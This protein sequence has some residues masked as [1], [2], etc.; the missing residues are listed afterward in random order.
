MLLATRPQDSLLSANLRAGVSIRVQLL[1]HEL[2]L[3]AALFD[4]GMPFLQELFD[5]ALGC[6]PALA[7][8]FQFGVLIR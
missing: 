7:L 6:L 4:F 1:L 2:I 8:L 5:V 3:D